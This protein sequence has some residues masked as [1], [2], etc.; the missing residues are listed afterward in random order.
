[1]QLSFLCSNKLPYSKEEEEEK[2]EGSRGERR[3]AWREQKNYNER[4]RTNI[5]KLYII[6]Y[7]IPYSSVHELIESKN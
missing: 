1:M 4:G 5:Q 2:K 3:N 6:F 7:V